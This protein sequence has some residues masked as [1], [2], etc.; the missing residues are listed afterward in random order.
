MIFYTYFLLLLLLNYIPCCIVMVMCAPIKETVC[1]CFHLSSRFSGAGKKL[2]ASAKCKECR[3]Y[4][5]YMY[6]YIWVFPKIWVPP[7]HPKMIIFSRKTHGCWVPPFLE[8]SIYVCMD[9]Y[10]S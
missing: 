5:I 4:N 1:F 9:A 8:T 6:I 2:R 10:N 7:K 3:G